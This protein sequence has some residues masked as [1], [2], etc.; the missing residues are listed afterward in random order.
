MAEIKSVVIHC[1]KCLV[2]F[3]IKPV[4]KSI[5]RAKPEGFAFIVQRPPIVVTFE[6]FVVDHRCE[7]SETGKEN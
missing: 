5:T 6:N 1:P 7:N 4:V 2:E 3:E